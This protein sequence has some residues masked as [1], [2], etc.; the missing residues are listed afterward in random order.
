M[1]FQDDIKKIYHD[2]QIDAIKNDFGKALLIGG[3]KKFPNGIVISSEFASISGNGYSA[4]GVPSTIYPIVASRC[5]LTQIFEPS[6][7][8]SD[9]VEYDPLRINVLAKTYQSILFGPG[10]A[11]TKENLKLLTTLLQD[12][13]GNLV[14]DATGLKLLSK[15]NVKE[16]RP[17]VLLTPHLGEA[18]S[19]FAS[20]VHSREAKDYVADAKKYIKLH[21]CSILLKSFDSIL[22][23]STGKVLECE[24]PKTPCLAKAGSGDGLA[25]YL[26]GLL[27]Y[28]DK[29]IGYHE[30]ILF[31][32]RM[33]HEAARLAQEK[34][35]PGYANILTAKEQ[36]VNLIR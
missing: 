13:E 6:I 17:N 28:A 32:N 19:L 9:S 26:T 7:L 1:N 15:V 25:G 10:I 36:I 31:A 33:I 34:Y 23:T 14:I 24:A 3:S 4:L 11:D 21:H 8:D 22:V 2:R 29:I 35:T 16:F 18:R 30:T 5:N 20:D 27:S 12:Y